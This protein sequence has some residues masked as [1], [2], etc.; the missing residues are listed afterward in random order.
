MSVRVRVCVY[1]IEKERECERILVPLLICIYLKAS[2]RW[3]ATNS[4]KN[5]IFFVNRSTRA[6]STNH[7]FH[8]FSKRK[9]FGQHVNLKDCLF[10]Q[11]INT[12]IL[13][14]SIKMFRKGNQ[15]AKKRPPSTLFSLQFEL[16]LTLPS[17]LVSISLSFTHTYIHA[18]TH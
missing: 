8:L 10:D 7:V 6:F 5:Q 15:I 3:L 13:K 17:L 14:Y 11:L 2:L 9:V 12:L 16:S 18:H 1:F 4:K